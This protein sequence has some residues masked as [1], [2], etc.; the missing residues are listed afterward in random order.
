MID[1]ILSPGVPCSKPKHPR[2]GKLTQKQMGA[3]TDKVRKEVR[4]RSGDICEVRIKCSGALAVHMAHLV[5]RR[6]IKRRTTAADLRHACDAC[7]THID[8]TGE[9]VREKKLMREKDAG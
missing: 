4:A 9:G 2:S 1:Y 3:I 8:T 7:H 5:G 6:V